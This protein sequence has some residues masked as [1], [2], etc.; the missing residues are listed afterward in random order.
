MTFPVANNNYSVATGTNSNASQ[1][2]YFSASDPTVNNVNFQPGQVWFN[3]SNGN[4]LVLEGFST[5]SGYPQATWVNVGTSL[6]NVAQYAV[7]VGGA[8]H[9]ISSITPDASTTKVLV[10]GGTSANPSWQNVSSS[11][12]V[13]QLNGDTGSATPSSGIITFNANTNSG[14]SVKFSGASSTMSLGVTDSNNNTIIGN[15][16]GNGT[17]SGSQNTGTGYNALHALT[18]GPANTAYGYGSCDHITTGS[19]NTGIGNTAL[20]GLVSGNYNVG[21]GNA[22][23]SSYTTSESSNICINSTG[24]V[25]ES[26]VLRIGA[27]T[28]TGTQQLNKAF[29][30][31]INSVTASNPAIVT[32]NTST[33]QLGTTTFVL[34]GSWTPGIAF[35]G[36]S[37]GITY[38]GTQGEYTQVGNV[39]YFNFIISLS[40]KGSSTGT[41]TVTGFPV[42]ANGL[43]SEIILTSTSNLTLGAGSTGVSISTSGGG[44]AFTIRGEIAGSGATNLTDAAFANNTR[45]SAVGFY[46]TS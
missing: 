18:N 6:G 34:G 22:A 15:L 3:T 43:A 28:G 38:S 46:F 12:A 31:G 29:I 21:I 17:L 24:T 44:T 10:S 13:I 16:A 37:T 33:D 11:G 41:A 2:I 35:G 45:L 40:N 32:I 8:D 20:T 25:S 14:S 36:A 30:S 26:H 9:T 1:I 7:L 23:G 39:V 19:S 42:A 4:F 5:S 27:G